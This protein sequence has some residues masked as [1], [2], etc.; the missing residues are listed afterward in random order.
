MDGYPAGSLDHNVPLLVASGLNSAAPELQLDGEL[1]DQGILLKSELPPLESQEADVLG[2]HFA[3]ID[4]HGKSWTSVA[5][6]EPYRFRVRTVGRSFLLPPHR[7]QLPESDEPPESTPV[8]HSPFSP[9]SPVSA[10]YPDGLIDAQWIRKHQDLVPSIYACFY[11]LANDNRLKADINELKRMLASSGYKTRVAVILLGDAS[12]GSA[13]LSEG[14]QD[15]LEGIRRG[16]ALDPKSIFY[17]PV[18]E[19]PAELK[20]IMDGIL[21]VLYGNAVEYYRDLGRHARKKRSRGVAPRPTVPPTSGTSRTLSLPDW[22]FRYDFKAAVFAEFRQELDAAIRSF[23]QA[24]GILMGPDVLDMMPSWSPRWN[25]ARLLADLI[26][27]RC[28]RIQLWMGHTS[29]AV[30]RWEAHRDRIGDFVDRRG[31]GTNNYGWQ[32]WEARWATIMAQLIEKVEVP[33]LTPAT[34]TIYLPPEKAV[35]SERLRPWELLHHTGYW[36]R[37][38]ARHLA[39]RR[40]LAHMMP[41]EDRSAPDPTS[42]AQAGSKSF[43]YDTYMCPV[44]HEEYPLSGPGVDHTQ[45]VID[46]L[47]TARSQFQARK[48]LRLAAEISL[49]CAREMASQGNWEGVLA[50]LRPLWDDGSFRSEDWLDAS[51]DLCWLLR[52]AAAAT[53]RGDLVVSIDWELMNTKFSKRTHWHYDF[54]KSLDGVKTDS[55]PVVGLTDDSAS[56]LVSASFI[57]RHKESKAGETC[58]AQLVLTSHALR[59]SAPIVL[60]SVRVAF[61]GSLRPLIIEHGDAGAVVNEE[62]VVAVDLEEK[63]SADADDELPLELRG[64]ANLTLRPGK[65]LV[66]EMA[67]PLREAGDAE[68]SSVTLSYQSD[69]FDL[70]YAL[71]FRETDPAVGWFSRELRKPRQPRS[72]ARSLHIQPRPPKLQIAL[73]DPQD[74]HYT[75]ETIEIQVELRNDEDEDANV[76]LDVHLFGERVPA[77]TVIADG[78]DHHTDASQEE[79]RISGVS[80]GHMDKGSSRVLAVR[81]DPA[82]APT[83]YDMHLR[84][85]YHLESDSATPIIQLL[86]IQLNV[87]APFEANYELVPRLHADPWPSLFNYEGV[88]EDADGEGEGQP[89]G[90]AQKWCLMCHYASF[91]TEDLNVTD[92]DVE[93]V[94]CVGGARCSVVKRPEIA[95][96]GILA[97]PKTMHEAQ[98]DLVAQKP[99][100]DDRHPVTLDLAFV[101]KWRRKRASASSAEND[102]RAVNTTRMPVGQYLVLGTEPRVLASVLHTSTAE[103]ETTWPRLMHLDVTIENPSNHFLTF[104][105]TMEPSD[106]FAFSGAKQTTVHLLPMSRRTTRYRLVPLV[107]GGA[108]VRPG[109]VVRDKYFQKVL[110]IIPTEGMKIDKDG[111]LVWVPGEDEDTAAAAEGHGAADGDGDGV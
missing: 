92:V 42:S 70:K 37:I 101:I 84:A 46:C 111:L 96:D 16:T 25:E 76:K 59:G 44:P 49:E 56:L 14:I 51:E 12:S 13:H 63:F 79:S 20:R 108:Y 61:D 4:S 103:G 89:K 22:N 19:S 36:Y 30:S 17:I 31:R 95:E 23:E 104:G 21:T 2:E 1:K 18:Q 27:I 83:S 33:G 55:K 81:I 34:M 52:R 62:T 80:L 29:L 9:L 75:N 60:S 69:A 48:Q 10:L 28:L 50:M 15:R 64:H 87:V 11:T 5:R 41:D 35:L 90:F 99:S 40:T 97:A 65:Q 67:V 91:A 105:L 43:A 102:D 88:G 94:S 86:P 109:L 3:E 53:G 78:N 58:P 82:S 110:R 68:A 57:F 38:A 26:S 6:D 66:L 74:Q 45:L 8:L 24:Y 77:F 85:I 98:F 71:H 54:G 32:A 39:A 72:G 106:S 100:L 107:A 47:I 73:L 7:A 93:I